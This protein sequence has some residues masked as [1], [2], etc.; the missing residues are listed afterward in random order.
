MTI[1]PIN[2]ICIVLEKWVRPVILLVC[3]ARKLIFPFSLLQAVEFFQS[4]EFMA[5]HFQ[6]VPDVVVTAEFLAVRV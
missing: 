5:I 4:L 2:G 1:I 6:N 3:I